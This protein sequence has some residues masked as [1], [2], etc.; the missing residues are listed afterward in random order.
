MGERQDPGAHC[1]AHQALL[2]DACMAV[3]RPWMELHGNSSL[4]FGSPTRAL[5]STQLTNYKILGLALD[6]G[7]LTLPL[8]EA[9]FATVLLAPITPQIGR[10]PLPPVGI[11]WSPLIW[12]AANALASRRSIQASHAFRNR[13]V[14]SPPVTV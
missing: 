7:P 1:C 2:T 13:H 3:C 4:S 6:R 12:S 9:Q 14:H 11:R 5:L 10:P 8:S